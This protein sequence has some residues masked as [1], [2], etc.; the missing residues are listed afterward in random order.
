MFVHGFMC[1]ICSSGFDCTCWVFL[2]T[3]VFIWFLGTNCP[4][5]A[6]EAGIAIHL[7]HTLLIFKCLAL[8]K[9]L[10]LHCINLDLVALVMIWWRRTCKGLNFGSWVGLWC[11]YNCLWDYTIY[12]MWFL[13]VQ[14][15]KLLGRL[16]QMF[17]I[18][19][20]VECKCWMVDSGGIS[21]R[22]FTCILS[23]IYNDVS[24]SNG[25]QLRRLCPPYLNII[26]AASPFAN[27]INND[28]WL[29]SLDGCQCCLLVDD[30]TGTLQ[31]TVHLSLFS[32]CTQH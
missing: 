30:W 4:K 2:F 24:A 9:N 25:K 23:Y 15:R 13:P 1:C 11:L 22:C 20:L 28:Y 10:S 17:Q 14:M 5:H 16:Y 8:Y 7:E 29:P 26:I 3:H 18:L 21:C 12:V 31:G 19:N 32:I 27:V 6:W